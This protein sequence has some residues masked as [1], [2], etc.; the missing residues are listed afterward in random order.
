[1]N[2]KYGEILKPGRNP[3]EE[4]NVII[5]I[6]KGSN[7]KYELDKESGLIF[8]DRML[9]SAMYYPCNYG[10]IPQTK[11]E[12]EDPVDVLVL[13][14]VPIVPKAVIRARPIGVLLTEDEK[15]NDSKII[16][17]A[18]ND[19][20]PSFSQVSDVEDIPDHVRNQITH[21]FE[22][23]KE[24]EEGKYVRIVGWENR[25]FA[26]EKIMKAMNMYSGLSR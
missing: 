10:F 7:V 11:E 22:H 9:L 14:N 8:V 26:K 19:V 3:P 17:T 5:E 16:A 15:G 21:F 24:L 2:L 6:P 12:D 4:I 25:E 13:G 20:D 18:L 1:M 23:Y